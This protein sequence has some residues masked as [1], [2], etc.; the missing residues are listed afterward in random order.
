M[1][2]TFP[3]FPIEASG[4]RSCLFAS[5]RSRILAGNLRMV[6]FRIVCVEVFPIKTILS[7]GQ[8]FAEPLEVDNFTLTQETDRI[9]DFRIMDQ[10][11]DIVIRGSGLLFCSHI[12]H[13]IRDHIS[14]TLEFTGVKRDSACCLRP[15]RS[16]MVDII[17]VESGSFDFFRR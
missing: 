2:G 15:E 13:Q 17:A 16:S 8:G 3:P 6:K 12:F 11:Q 4:L 7:D 5:I 14:L 9:A 10:P 1:A